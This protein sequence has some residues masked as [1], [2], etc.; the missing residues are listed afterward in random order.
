MDLADILRTLAALSAVL[1][2]LG[3][4][5][6]MARRFGIVVPGSGQRRTARLVLTERIVL[7]PKRSIALIRHGSTEHLILLAPE[8]TLILHDDRQALAVPM[9][10]DLGACRALSSIGPLPSDPSPPLWPA[11]SAM[12]RE[13]LGKPRRDPVP[14]R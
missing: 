7:D 2:L 8:G 4:G 5:L 9:V 13:P 14:A 3:A 6:W 12:R 10:I 11:P 1:A